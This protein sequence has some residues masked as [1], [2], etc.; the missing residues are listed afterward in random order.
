MEK[1]NIEMILSIFGDSFDVNDFTKIIGIT[2]TVTWSKGDLNVEYPSRPSRQETHW[3]YSTGSIESYNMDDIS[4]K[5]LQLFGNK[6]EILKS[7]ITHHNLYVK[8]YIVPIIENNNIPSF[9]FDREFLKFVY[10]IGA[11]IDMDMYIN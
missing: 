8:I 10:K 5:I 11:E 3:G 6:I 7:F 2:P 9:Y 1:T 4:K